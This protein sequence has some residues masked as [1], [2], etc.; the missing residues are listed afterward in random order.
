MLLSAL[1]II[2]VGGYILIGGWLFLDALYMTVVTFTTVGFQEV[3]ATSPAGRIF[4]IFLMT[5]GV[6]EVDPPVRTARGLS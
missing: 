2:G 4:T 6:A 5:A 3:H 1:L